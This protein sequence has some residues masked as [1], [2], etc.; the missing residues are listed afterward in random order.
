[1]TDFIAVCSEGVYLWVL[2][3]DNMGKWEK[4]SFFLPLDG[5]LNLYKGI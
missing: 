1:V 2:S 4:T 5:F 3:V